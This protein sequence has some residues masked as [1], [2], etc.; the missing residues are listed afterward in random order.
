MAYIIVKKDIQIKSPIDGSMIT[1]R[2]QLA[3]HNAK[4][5]VVLTEEYGRNSGEAYFARKQRERM[6]RH[7]SKEAVADRKQDIKD[8]I[9]KLERK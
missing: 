8:A 4:H 6:E 5:G 2:R 9:E 3:N 7:N 1:T